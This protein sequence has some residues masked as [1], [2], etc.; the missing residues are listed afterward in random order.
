MAK[1]KSKILHEKWHEYTEAEIKNI[2]ETHCKECPYLG[3]LNTAYGEKINPYSCCD[4][5]YVTGKR[6]GCR[7][8]VC[9]HYKDKIGQKNQFGKHAIGIG[10]QQA[11]LNV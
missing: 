5:L 3:H 8:E 7:P 2:V 1:K 10:G 9:T 11:Y 4:Y 6:R